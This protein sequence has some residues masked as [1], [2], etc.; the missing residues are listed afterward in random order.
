MDMTTIGMN[1]EVIAGK[2]KEFED[3]FLKTID[4]LKT[5]KGHIESK[6][7]ED[8]ASVGSYLILSVWDTKEDFSAFI[9][10]DAFKNVTSWGKAEILRSRPKHKI[11]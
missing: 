2:E 11:Y 3:G 9:Q 7:Y 10:S 5:V 4:Y 8:V 6:L 1:Y